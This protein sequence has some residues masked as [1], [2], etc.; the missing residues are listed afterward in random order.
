MPVL[1]SSTHLL[2]DTVMKI[3]FLKSTE[4]DGHTQKCAELTWIRFVSLETIKARVTKM[5]HSITTVGKWH[6]LLE[7]QL[8]AGNLHSQERCSSCPLCL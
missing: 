5:E 3:L 8:R 4:E 2:Q 1:P 6:H 7:N